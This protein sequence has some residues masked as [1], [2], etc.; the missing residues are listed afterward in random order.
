MPPETTAGFRLSPQQERLWTQAGADAAGFRSQCA[1][2]IEGPVDAERLRAALTSLVGRYEILRTVFPHQAGLKVPFQVILDPGALHG[3][4]L[5]WKTVDLAEHGNG[6]RASGSVAELLQSELTAP[7]D[8]ERGP[9]V[10]AVLGLS[11]IHI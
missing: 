8:L 2:R 9:V 3:N 6:V 10:H 4:T 11:L 7:I 1:V 5:A